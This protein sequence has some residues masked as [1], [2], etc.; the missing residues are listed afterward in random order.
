MPFCNFSHFNSQLGE[1]HALKAETNYHGAV[2]KSLSEQQFCGSTSIYFV[3]R[4]NWTILSL[5][6][7]LTQQASRQ[8]KYRWISKLI[9]F[10]TD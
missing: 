2:H 3:V 8:T 6:V 9:K 10:S 7:G 4:Q 5:L 1:K